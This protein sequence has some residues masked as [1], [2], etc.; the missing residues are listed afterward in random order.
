MKRL[1]DNLIKGIRQYFRK[2]GI[3]KAVIGLSGG[4]DSALSLRLTADA[5]GNRNVTALIMPEKGLKDKDAVEFCKKLKV[6]YK[7]IWIDSIL[8]NFKRIKQNKVSL[9]NLKPRIRMLL[10]YNYAN[11]NNALVIGTSNKTELKLGYFTKHGDGACDLEVIGDLYKTEVREL[12]RYLKLPES[13]IIKIPSAGL[14]KGQTDEKEIGAKYEDIDKMLQ[15]KKKL[16]QRIKKLIDKNKH[17]T[18]RIP[19]IKK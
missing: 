15:G 1:Y 7:I 2:A 12:A 8:K 13:I 17:K 10:L 4:I 14:F 18:E 9:I 6:N 5:I 19:V 11:A 16:N 3:G